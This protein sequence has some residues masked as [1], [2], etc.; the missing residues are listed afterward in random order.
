[1]N[2]L[3]PHGDTD[4]NT[5]NRP[6]LYIPPGEAIDLGNGFASLHPALGDLM[7]VVNAGEMALVHR[8]GY[9]DSSLSHFDGQRIWE[10]GDPTRADFLEGWLYRYVSENAVSAGVDLPVL[11]VQSS[12]PLLLSGD[13]R[14]VNI[15]NPDSF[16]YIEDDPKK[17]KVA[18]AWRR[19]HEG[20]SGLERYRPVL[21]QTAVKLAD[22][23][24]EY[25]SWDQQNWN[26]TDPDTGQ[27]LFPVSDETN[28]DDP[29]GPGGKKFP[30]SSYEFF[31]SLKVCALSL[32]ESDGLSGTGTRIAGTQLGGWDT[33]GSQGQTTGT[34]ATLLSQV[35][36]GFRSLR[37]ALSG[38]AT[39]EPRGYS[40]IWDRTL[41]TTLS[42]FGRTTKE[43]GSEG[44]DHAKASCLFMGGGT[45]N[46]GVYNCDG[47]S[48]PAGVMF[49]L[50]D[51]Y[52][53][54]ATDFR[55]I[56]WEM[57][58]DHM[59]SDPG[60]RETVFPGY[61]AAGLPGQELGLIS[62]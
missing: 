23:L 31:R 24:D 49:G 4:F 22:T 53:L 26:P 55:A 38:V 41:V 43:N 58:R 48:W 2:A 44:T 12:S 37:I 11:T 34:Q 10:N 15:A 42:E 59:E 46:G 51:R 30:T 33:H 40:G 8:V 50:S 56:F 1:L 5:T 61:G 45:V 3:T 14:F 39:N 21:S 7:D 57:L 17:G 27:Y 20:M 28:P 16:D 52:L 18:G 9:A 25:E 29:Q 36:Y 32:L 54:Q 47:G 6:T 60:S 13:E 62:V 19:I 35:A